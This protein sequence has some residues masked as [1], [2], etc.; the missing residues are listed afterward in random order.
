MYRRTRQFP[1][2]WFKVGQKKLDGPNH[3]SRA[4]I[5]PGLLFFASW[6]RCRYSVQSF[7]EAKFVKLTLTNLI[8]FTILSFHYNSKS[9]TRFFDYIPCLKL[10]H[11]QALPNFHAFKC[12]S[13]LSIVE[14]TSVR[15][16]LVLQKIFGRKMWI[17]RTGE[18][19]HHWK[20]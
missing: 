11:R 18:S 14:S 20:A 10:L 19:R 15:S 5:A 16:M 17:V 6:A 3:I 8:G 4:K 13:R 12:D 7:I 1:V 9:D 2:V